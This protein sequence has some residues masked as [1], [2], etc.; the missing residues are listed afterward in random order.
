MNLEII[1]YSDIIK[2]CKYNFESKNKLETKP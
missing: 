1:L 2:C